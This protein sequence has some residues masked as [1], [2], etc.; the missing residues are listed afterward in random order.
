MTAHPGASLSASLRGGAVWWDVLFPAL[1]PFFVMAELMLGFGVVHFFGTLLDPLMRPVFRLPG[2]AGFVV[3]MGLVSGY[4]VGARLD[5]QAAGTGPDQPERGRTARRLHDDIRPD[6]PH[7]RRLGR[8]LSPSR[9]GAG[10]G[11]RALR[12]RSHHRADASASTAAGTD[13][14]APGAGARRLPAA[15]AAMHEART[16]DGR[17]FG[18]LLQDASA[19][20]SG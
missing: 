4:P 11:G 7:R 18:R 19:R 14:P 8:L 13:H 17:P 10:A 16:A 9:A 3:T 15:L 12:R 1:F 6:L 5:V 2:I 20:R